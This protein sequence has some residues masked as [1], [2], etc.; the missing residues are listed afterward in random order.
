VVVTVDGRAL[1][2]R[3]LDLVQSVHVEESL[4]SQDKV[5]IVVL[6]DTDRSSRWTSA[7]DTLVAPAKPFTVELTR[8]DAVYAVDARSVTASWSY[9]PGGTSTLTVE[10]LDRSMEMDRE[11]VQRTWTDTTDTAIA[12]ELFSKYHLKPE[13]G[14][15][16]AGTDA[17]TYS[18][19]QAGTDWQFLNSLAA[20]NGFDL[21]VETV[22]GVGIG[23]FRRVQID[24]PGTTLA[25]GYGDLGGP[26]TASVQL[27]A[28]Q[29][30]HVTRT[31]PGTADVDRASDPGTGDAMGARSLGGATVVR[32]HVAGDASVHDAQRTA[33]AMAERSAFAATLS[34]T[35]DKPAMPLVRARRTV[36]VGGLGEALD[37]LWLVQSVTHTVTKGGHTQAVTLVRN[38]LGSA[39]AAA[40]AALASL[41]WVA[42]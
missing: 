7:L 17:D 23:V 42:L 20:R 27:L 19:Q 3:D 39:V 33:K 2:G 29:Q 18:P 5:S 11:Q 34:V 13:C 16:P 40:A 25:L 10:G 1:G 28:G 26:A 37:G 14:D 6:M 4:G 9:A 38:A 21:H 30:V 31:V 32:T 35:L 15:T 12:T 8:G 41:G 36:G 22:G 24:K